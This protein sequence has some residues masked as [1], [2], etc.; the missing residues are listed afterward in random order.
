MRA[1]CSLLLVGSTVVGGCG[2][3]G[4]E[5]QPP[6]DNNPPSHPQ[7]GDPLPLRRVID[8]DTIVVSLGGI[9]ETIRFKGVGAPELK[10][11]C[12]SN[13]DCPSGQDCQF[14]ELTD[15]TCGIIGSAISEPQPCAVAAKQLVI[16]VVGPQVE[17]VFE[18]SCS[19]D[20]LVQCRDV[21]DR[22][23]AYVILGDNSDLGKRVIDAGL[24]NMYA[25]NNEQFDRRPDY[26][27][28]ELAAQQANL[29]LWGAGCP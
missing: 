6:I 7:L 5:Y 12:W 10:P 11:K 16:D 4:E 19:S 1:F 28:A 24:A 27:A 26:E 17:L 21:W 3:D 29:G 8:G 14:R 2:V 25:L 20:P 15:R 18:Q 22:L 13:A 9:D 23:L